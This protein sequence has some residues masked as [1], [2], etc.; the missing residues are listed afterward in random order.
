[1]KPVYRHCKPFGF[2][3]VS[4]HGEL[5]GIVELLSFLDVADLFEVFVVPEHSVEFPVAEYVSELLHD[6]CLEDAEQASDRFPARAGILY[7]L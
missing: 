5:S 3:A 7:P 6:Q 1:V 2:D 4:K